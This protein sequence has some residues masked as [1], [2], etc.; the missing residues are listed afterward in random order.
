MITEA[1][2]KNGFLQM[3]QFHEKVGALPGDEQAQDAAA[4]ETRPLHFLPSRHSRWSDQTM[5]CSGPQ[6]HRTLFHPEFLFKDW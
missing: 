2:G 6:L 1:M 3:F 5:C 4:L